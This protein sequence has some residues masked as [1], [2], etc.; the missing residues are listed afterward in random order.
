MYCIPRNRTNVRE[1]TGA[2]FGIRSDQYRGPQAVPF[3]GSFLSP[4]FVCV[5]TDFCAS[6]I[7]LKRLPSSVLLSLEI[8]WWKSCRLGI[9]AKDSRAEVRQISWD[10]VAFAKMFKDLVH[11]LFKNISHYSYKTW[12][13]VEYGNYGILIRLMFFLTRRWFRRKAIG[14]RGKGDDQNTHAK[15]DVI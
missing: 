9:S 6:S 11:G 15:N 10:E 7:I 14:K 1:P 13:M 3:W 5:I 12:T 8:L 2:C 4:V